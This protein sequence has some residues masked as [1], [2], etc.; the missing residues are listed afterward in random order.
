MITSF[1]KI[2]NIEKLIYLKLFIFSLILA[3]IFSLIIKKIAIYFKILDVPDKER[4]IHKEAVPLLG[5]LA[6]FFSFFISLFLVR[7]QLVSGNLNYHH[8]LGFFLGA[9]IL[10]IGGFLDDKYNLSPGKQI[11]FPIIA[12]FLVILGGVNI[13][14]ITNPFGGYFY[15]D[16]LHINLGHIGNFF[17]SFNVLSA[18]LIFLWLMG[19]S[20]TTKILDGLDGLVSGITAIGAFIIFLFTISEQYYQGDIAL[21]SIILFGA[22]LGFLILNFYPAK[23]F[24]GEGG[25]LFLGFSLG[26]LAIISGGKIAIALLI[27]G[28]PILDL[29]W[30]I[31]RRSFS[32]RNPFKTGDRRH[33]HFRIFD[34]AKSQKKAVLTYYFLSALFG[35][36]AL[37][38]QSRGKIFALGV[39]VIVMLLIIF[40]LNYFE[41]EKN[42]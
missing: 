20:Y 33:L 19:I 40:I 23:I 17:L 12:S 34:L 28:I 8:W 6:I 5:G 35:F 36:S 15:L 30:S 32:G 38:L 3:Y 22:S 39:L 13:E 18:L 42:A 9:L 2:I 24:L 1:I 41:K 16:F 37:F 21:A 10:M 31:L 11:I 25:S 14:K 26:V 27:M 4:K 29:F 7:A